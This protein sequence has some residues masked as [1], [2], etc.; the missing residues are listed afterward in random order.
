MRFLTV[1]YVFNREALAIEVGEDVATVLCR[2]VRQRGAPSAT[3]VDN[4]TEFTGQNRLALRLPSQ[5]DQ[6]YFKAGNS[7]RQRANRVLQRLTPR[8]MREPELVRIDRRSEETWRGLK[9]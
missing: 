3:S 1:I 4:G 9:T 5:H 2:Q 6:G 8:R 7:D